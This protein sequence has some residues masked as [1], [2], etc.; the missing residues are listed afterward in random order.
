MWTP[1]EHTTKGPGSL[2]LT[3]VKGLAL[4]L[5]L[6]KP[7]LHFHGEVTATW[8]VLYGR[9]CGLQSLSVLVQEMEGSDQTW[10][11]LPLSLLHLLKGKESN[12]EFRRLLPGSRHNPLW[13]SHPWLG[14]IVQT[15]PA[16]SVLCP[17]SFLFT[18]LSHSWLFFPCPSW[19]RLLFWGLEIQD[20]VSSPGRLVKGL[21]MA[22]FSLGLYMMKGV[23][24]LCGASFIRLLIPFKKSLPLWPNHL[25]VTS[26][27]PQS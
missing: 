18:E 15:L 17:D 23:R 20:E 7:H 6:F 3:S 9:S 8:C 4:A 14:N 25:L 21:Q 24:D 26:P 13:C 5:S 2:A 1:L 22:G 12:K 16:P 19:F 11:H 10:G 27:P